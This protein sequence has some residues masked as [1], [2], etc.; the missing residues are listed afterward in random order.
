MILDGFEYCEKKSGEYYAES[1]H[2][3]KERKP[4]RTKNR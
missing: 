4:A 2:L 3:S 1:F